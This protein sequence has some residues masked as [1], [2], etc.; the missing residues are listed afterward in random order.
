MIMLDM[1]EHF[2]QWSA[3]CVTDDPL[4]PLP[5]RHTHAQLHKGR[6]STLGRHEIVCMRYANIVLIKSSLHLSYDG[7]ISGY[8]IF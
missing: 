7:A 3:R 8:V 2:Q 5:G 1:N 4:I 6:P